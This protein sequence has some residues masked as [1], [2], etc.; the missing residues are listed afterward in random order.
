MSENHIWLSF[1][2]EAGNLGICIIKATDIVEAVRIA[3]ALGCNPGGEVAGWTFD[4]DKAP[5]EIKALPIGT[6]LQRAD[7]DRH[8][9]EHPQ[10][11]GDTV[12]APHRPALGA[13]ERRARP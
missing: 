4:M 7:L 5:S 8:K 6:L 2:G 13:P 10:Q 11:S 12:P 9:V 1:V 3:Y